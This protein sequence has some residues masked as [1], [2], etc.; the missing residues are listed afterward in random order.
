M[1]SISRQ[2]KSVFPDYGNHAKIRPL[3][4]LYQDDKESFGSLSTVTM[5]EGKD[6]GSS[7]NH[8]LGFGVRG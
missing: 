7:F 5:S 1:S 3:A 4:R 2:T 6:G 8:L